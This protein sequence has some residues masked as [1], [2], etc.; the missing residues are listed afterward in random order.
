MSKNQKRMCGSGAELEFLGHWQPGRAA[1]SGVARFP[2]VARVVRTT[3]HQ[4]GVT[5]VTT[6]DR[7]NGR[8][9][10][11]L[12]SPAGTNPWVGYIPLGGVPILKSRPDI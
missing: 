2:A 3:T 4:L 12:V 6:T 7:Q 9:S 5:Q 1:G 10:T 8:L 11:R